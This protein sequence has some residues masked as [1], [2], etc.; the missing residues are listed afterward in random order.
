MRRYWWF[1][2]FSGRVRQPTSEDSVSMYVIALRR[3]LQRFA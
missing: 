2:S 3:S 1:V